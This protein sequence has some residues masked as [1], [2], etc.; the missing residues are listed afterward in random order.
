MSSRFTVDAGKL[1]EALNVFLK[2]NSEPVWLIRDKQM[3]LSAIAP[4]SVCQITMKFPVK[5]DESYECSFGLLQESLRNLV[6]YGRKA[7][8][9]TIELDDNA[10]YV[11]ASGGAK[12]ETKL[13]LL[14]ITDKKVL[15]VD[16]LKEFARFD[17]KHADFKDAL[18]LLN[19]N[20]SVNVSY[21]DSV[22]ML[23]QV[24]DRRNKTTLSIN[25]VDVVGVPPN[26]LSRF[27]VD[28]LQMLLPPKSFAG[29]IVS[30]YI[31]QVAP[32]MLYVE[33]FES[34]V[35]PRVDND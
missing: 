9:F 34:V 31:D 10:L 21:A 22:L 28:W 30:L 18:S 19:D 23:D 4:S 14:D 33:D 29:E 8:T 2:L 20:L 25:C 13:P 6:R 3:T 7:Q 1:S 35:A 12:I 5:V 32:M 17:V 11:E 24:D 27:G 15:P 26:S 16:R